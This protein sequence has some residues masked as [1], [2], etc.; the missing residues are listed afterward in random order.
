MTTMEMILVLHMS[1]HA[2]VQ[3]GRS[4]INCYLQ[5]VTSRVT[6][7]IVFQLMVT[8]QLLVH[9]PNVTMEI[10]LVLHISSKMM[11]L[12]GLSK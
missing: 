10:Y 3:L 12:L 2:Q 6:L 1:L 7:G 9:L 8:M 5:M 11:V 4:R